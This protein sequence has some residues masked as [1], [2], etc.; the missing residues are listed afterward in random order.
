[1]RPAAP[2]R[3]PAAGPVR[4]RRRHGR[5]REDGGVE[6][7]AG[8]GR[9]RSAEG[10][11]RR[12]AAPSEPAAS[13]QLEG[14]R[15]HRRHRRPGGGRLPGGVLQRAA[16]RVPGGPGSGKAAASPRRQPRLPPAGRAGRAAGEGRGRARGWGCR[17]GGPWRARRS[18]LRAGRG[19]RWSDRVYLSAVR[20]DSGRPAGTARPRPSLAAVGVS[21]ASLKLASSRGTLP[22]ASVEEGRGCP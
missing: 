19:P 4:C 3:P 22:F 2:Q 15:R 10:A 17:R 12:A 14:R 8:G 7:G 16:G 21:T 11:V 6:S 1:M 5:F 18:G 13:A 9:P 20:R